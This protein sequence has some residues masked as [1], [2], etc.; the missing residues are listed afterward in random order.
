MS[1]DG[2]K[3]K[4]IENMVCNYKKIAEK[5]Q[6]ECIQLEKSEILN[7]SNVYSVKVYK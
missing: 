7:K 5:V 1:A 6:I 2:E 3:D 4:T